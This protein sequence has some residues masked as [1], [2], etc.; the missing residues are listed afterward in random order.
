MEASA[1]TGEEGRFKR[2]R[3]KIPA[4]LDRLPLVVRVPSMPELEAGSRVR[5]GVEAPDLIDR[6]VQCVWRGQASS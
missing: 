4:R 6:Q 5:L 3:T 1:A 2:I